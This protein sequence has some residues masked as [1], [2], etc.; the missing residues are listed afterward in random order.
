MID[1]MQLDRDGFLA[2]LEQ[3]TTAAIVYREAP[4]IYD[5]LRSIF[6]Q[7]CND[8][9][10]REWAFQWATDKLGYSYDQIYDRWLA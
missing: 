3:R 8:S 1:V 6:W 4:N 9:L 7:S 2:E 10:L 5:H